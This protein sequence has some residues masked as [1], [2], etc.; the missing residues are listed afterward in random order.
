MNFQSI[1]IVI[2]IVILIVCLILI[3]LALR[4]ARYSQQWPPLVGECP[5]YWTDISGNGAQCVN[6]K[7]LGMCNGSLQTGQHLT[8]DFTQAPYIGE[9]G[10]CAKYKWANQCGI[11]W[12]G[13]TS[14]VDNPCNLKPA[15][16]S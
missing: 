3:G 5:D 1:V 7:D 16:T 12:D 4:K 11:T 15:T 6:V 14:G 9:N 13:I 2:A 10:S 8:M